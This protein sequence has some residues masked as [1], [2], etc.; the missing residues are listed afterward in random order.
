VNHTVPLPP[1][2]PANSTANVTLVCQC[3]TGY[4]GAN[5]AS[6]ANT[7]ITATAITA[8]AIAGII[9]GIVACFALAGGG[10]FAAAQT[11]GN[12]AVAPVVNNPIYRGTGNQG[13]N[14]LFKQDA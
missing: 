9:V 4:T 5:C 6:V 2:S 3:A 11:M 14:P 10:A 12:G 8:G 7:I 13:M 1:N